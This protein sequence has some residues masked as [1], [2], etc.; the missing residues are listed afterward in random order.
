[1]RVDCLDTKKKNANRCPVCCHLATI[2]RA[3]HNRWSA[4]RL[5]LASNICGFTHLAYWFLGV[6]AFAQPVELSWG[7]HSVVSWLQVVKYSREQRA[8]VCGTD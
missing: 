7:K 6:S 2:H 3:A 4:S 1:V 8:E 5:P